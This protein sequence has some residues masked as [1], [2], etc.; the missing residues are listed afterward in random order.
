MKEEEVVIKIELKVRGNKN[1]DYVYLNTEKTFTVVA[2]RHKIFKIL[3]AME[4][5]IKKAYVEVLPP[6]H[7]EV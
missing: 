3:E 5:K 6:N 2:S 4:K 7:K 1:G